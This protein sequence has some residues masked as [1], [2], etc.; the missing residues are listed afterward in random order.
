MGAS[1]LRMSSRPPIPP[2]RRTRRAGI[3]RSAAPIALGVL[4]VGAPQWLGGVY[5]SAMI[6][7]AC[8]SGVCLLLA[9]LSVRSTDLPRGLL[10]AVALGP[11]A[12]TALQ[13]APLPCGL[14]ELVS[15]LSAARLREAY[16]LFGLAKPAQCVLTRDPGA[17]L[18]ELVKAC[19][20]S[21]V[22]L[23]AAMLAASGRQRWV[24]SAVS[25]STV[26]MALI[27]IGHAAVSAER[28]FGV[29]QPLELRNV[30]FVAPLL[31]PNNLGGFLAMGVPVLIGLALEQ[32]NPRIRIAMLGTVG[33][34]AAAALMTRSRGAA[35]AVALGPVIYALLALWRTRVQSSARE[36]RVR[37]AGP[38]WLRIATPLALTGVLALAGYAWLDELVMEFE[39]SGWDKIDLIAR[40]SKFALTA[41]WVGVGRGAFAGAFVGTLESQYR[42]DYAESLLV[43][44]AVDWGIAFALAFTAGLAFLYVRAVVRTRSHARIGALAGVATVFAQNLVD[45]GLELV[46]PAVVATALFGAAVSVPQSGSRVRSR[47]HAIRATCIA[48]VAVSLVMPLL[49][50]SQLVALHE[51]IVE[52]QLRAQ[53]STDAASRDRRA[54]AALLQRASLAH[55]SEPMLP[56]LGAHEALTAGDPRAGR[57]INRAMLLAPG[58]AAPHVQAAQWLWNRGL[59][60]QALIELRSAADLDLV[61]T[62]SIICQM[63]RAEPQAI[64]AAAPTSSVRTYFLER[65]VRCLPQASPEARALDR[66]LMR[67]APDFET[68]HLREAQRLLTEQ[69]PVEAAAAARAALAIEPASTLGVDL[70]AQALASAG[71]VEQAVLAL[72]K[73]RNAGADPAVL[74]ERK[75]RIV[76]AAGDAAAMRE[77][78]LALRGWIGADATR[79]H[80]AYQLEAELEEKLGNLGAALHANEEAYRIA[81][82]PDALL[83]VARISEQLGNLR[84]AEQAYRT[85]CDLKSGPHS[86]AGC[87]HLERLRSASVNR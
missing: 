20:I 66:E 23:S 50:A 69:K 68:P 65:V 33:L 59:R 38:P 37:Q 28:V 70:L 81:G 44:W 17:T 60:R 34:V 83:G 43:Q 31:N 73:G 9:L 27:A 8:A 72:E 15:P 49:V 87:S 41:P 63:A 25:V 2:G 22:L 10:L 29:Y 77:A 67:S 47:A 55:P 84:R 76:T 36:P 56:I 75:A 19:A 74:F 26:L 48:L 3:A 58:W 40:A 14:V 62:N 52:E 4:L 7:T 64:V 53:A 82:L 30:R 80:Y 71:R 6:G 24:F 78:L 1:Q 11:L 16:A 54:F 39:S 45:L 86:Q 61:A 21:S 32:A 57:F 5:P 46:G 12:F 85:V 42:S 35:G 18:E 51:P 79:L 13:L